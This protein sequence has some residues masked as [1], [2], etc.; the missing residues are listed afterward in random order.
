MSVFG[1]FNCHLFQVLLRNLFA[2][3]ETG[4]NL[5]ENSE[6]SSLGGRHLTSAWKVRSDPGLRKMARK[7]GSANVIMQ[8]DRIGKKRKCLF[9]A[10]MRESG[11]E[12]YAPAFVSLRFQ[13]MW[14]QEFHGIRR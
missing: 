8:R 5:S 9:K 2:Q 7:L 4:P 12:V 14:Q 1:S 10:W 13:V 3:Y 11:R 6:R